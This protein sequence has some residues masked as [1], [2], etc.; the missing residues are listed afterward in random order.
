M[1]TLLK[2]NFDL[3]QCWLSG[4]LEPAQVKILIE[5]E[6]PKTPKALE[7]SA[8]FW[9]STCFSGT[10]DPVRTIGEA[11]KSEQVVPFEVLCLYEMLCISKIP[12][13]EILAVRMP[14]LFSWNINSLYPRYESTFEKCNLKCLVLSVSTVP[15]CQ[16]FYH[17]VFK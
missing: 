5:I 13:K 11:D 15:V 14:F 8:V 9:S 10:C 17:V 12:S 3:Y 7:T 16:A 2:V 6:H 4:A 1:S